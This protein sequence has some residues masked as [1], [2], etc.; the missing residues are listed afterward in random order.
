MKTIA[1]VIGVVVGLG[2]AFGQTY[3]PQATGP[4]YQSPVQYARW[5]SLPGY[6]PSGGYCLDVAA[7]R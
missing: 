7:A 4:V 3:R 2:I 6:P 1:C 5:G